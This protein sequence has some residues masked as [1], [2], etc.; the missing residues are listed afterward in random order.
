MVASHVKVP[1]DQTR[2]RK[3][4]AKKPTPKAP[5]KKKTPAKPS[6][7]KPQ[8]S[9]DQQPDETDAAYTAFLVYRALGRSRSIRRTHSDWGQVADDVGANPNRP[10]SL[11][12]IEKWHGA[13]SWRLRAQAWDAELEADWQ[14]EVQDRRIRAA[15]RNADIAEKGMNLVASQ[16]DVLISRVDTKDPDRGLDVLDIRRLVDSLSRLERLAY[17]DPTENVQVTGKD[18]GPVEF[19][20]VSK[21]TDEQRMVRMEEVQTELQSR[22]DEMRGQTSEQ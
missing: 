2:P 15:R 12:S 17:G 20:D 3:T 14:R 21:L 5:A 22:L 18:G 13:N 11:T 4:A 19:E 8:N 10:A 7:P 1:P 9:W 6:R 16:L